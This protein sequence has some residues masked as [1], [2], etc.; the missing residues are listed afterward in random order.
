MFGFFSKWK[1]CRKKQIGFWIP[2]LVGSLAWFFNVS[3]EVPAQKNEFKRARTRRGTGMV[4]LYTFS[5]RILC[6]FNIRPPQ[7][8]WVN[9]LFPCLLHTHVFDKDGCT[10]ILE[11]FLTFETP[12][13][14]CHQ[15][16]NMNHTER[17]FE[18]PCP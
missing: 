8:K 18:S 17:R 9:G 12:S 13:N 2:V 10:I 16:S 6:Y 15:E 11:P 3:F 14:S 4:R 1:F 7:K 5:V